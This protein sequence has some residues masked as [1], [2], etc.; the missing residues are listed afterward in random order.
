M[1][2]CFI[3]NSSWKYILKIFFVRDFYN[4]W[5]ISL[6]A[7]QNYLIR[8]MSFQLLLITYKL[9]I[10]V[11][12]APLY[13]YIFLFDAL[14]ILNWS[15]SFHSSRISLLTRSVT[16]STKKYKESVCMCPTIHHWYWYIYLTFFSCLKKNICNWI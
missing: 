3:K 14:F 5:K 12:A 13:F 8:T 11:T 7:H 2:A 16:K 4:Q 6:K 10:V 9:N 1:F 15:L